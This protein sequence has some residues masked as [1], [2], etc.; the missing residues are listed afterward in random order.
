MDGRSYIPLAFAVTRMRDEGLYAV[1]KLLRE[2]TA[3]ASRIT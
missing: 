2:K 1:A 3:S